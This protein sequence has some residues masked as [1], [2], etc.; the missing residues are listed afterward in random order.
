VVLSRFIA[1]GL[2]LLTSHFSHGTSHHPRLF[3]PVPHHTHG[4]GET[5]RDT[6]AD[7][8]FHLTGDPATFQGHDN[9]GVGPGNAF[10]E[11][12]L[13]ANPEARIGLIPY[14]KGGSSKTPFLRPPQSGGILRINPKK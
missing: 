12:V 1:S 3:L 9:A 2:P 8:P 14:A 7:I 6:A 13:V 11:A 4:T 10:A 5:D